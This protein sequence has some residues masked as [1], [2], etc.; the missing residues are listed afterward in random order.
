MRGKQKKHAVL[1]LL[2]LR[3]SWAL[4]GLLQVAHFLF[5]PL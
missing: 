5:K 1:H 4:G 2:F 3:L